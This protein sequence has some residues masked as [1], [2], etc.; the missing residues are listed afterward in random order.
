MYNEFFL[1]ACPSFSLFYLLFAFRSYFLSQILYDILLSLSSFNFYMPFPIY[2]FFFLF[3]LFILLLS[4]LFI[5]FHIY[6]FPFSL[7]ALRRIHI[8]RDYHQGSQRTCRSNQEEW[9]RGS[10]LR[11]ILHSWL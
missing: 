10:E 8:R 5:V 9:R 11:T 2:Y 4:F 3:F 7:Q 1:H 6:S